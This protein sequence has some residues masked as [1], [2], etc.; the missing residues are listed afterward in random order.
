MPEAF[1][2]ITVSSNDNDFWLSLEDGRLSGIRSFLRS[3][4]KRCLRQLNITR[5]E[6]SDGVIKWPSYSSDDVLSWPTFGSGRPNLDIIVEWTSLTLTSDSLEIKRG[7][8]L[9]TYVICNA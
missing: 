6:I 7:G 1:E 3:S 9:L 5:F 2:P 8:N 4:P